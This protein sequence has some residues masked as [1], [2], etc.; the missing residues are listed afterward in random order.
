MVL[1]VCQDE[2][3]LYR[4]RM[5]FVRKGD[6]SMHESQRL[7]CAEFD[8]NNTCFWIGTDRG[9]L[10]CISVETGEE[11]GEAYNVSPEIE[12]PITHLRK[13]VGIDSDNVF[14]IVLANKEAVIYSQQRKDAKPVMYGESDE[15]QSYQGKEICNALVAYNSKFF[16][17]GIPAHRALGFFSF[18]RIEFTFKP[19]KWLT[20]VSDCIII[21]FSTPLRTSLWTTT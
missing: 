20:K 8:A 17:I 21:V 7:M 3:A 14:L 9:L 19:V 2:Y 5:D 4:G 12:K 6:T 15:E 1:V 13:F 11:I 10:I 16:C 18:D